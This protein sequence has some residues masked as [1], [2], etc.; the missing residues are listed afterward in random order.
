MSESIVLVISFSAVLNLAILSLLSWLKSKGKPGNFWLGCMFFAASMAILDNSL[1][2]IGKG[3]VSLYHVALMLNLGWGA[4]LVA[5]ARSLR[6]PAEKAI[7][8]NW[9]LFIPVYLYLP[10]FILTLVE[11]HWRTDTITLA[12]AGK[13]TLFGTAYNL[14]ICGYSILSNT[15]LLWQEHKPKPKPGELSPKSKTKEVLWVMLVLQLLAFVPFIL[16]LDISYILLYMP[17]FGQVFFLYIF[18]RITYS[19]HLLFP[20]S[21]REKENN[22][23]AKYSTIK[24]NSER[25][26][27]IRERVVEYMNAKKPYLKMDYSLTDMSRDLKVL[28]TQ[29]S[30]VINSKLNCSFPEY[31]NS[32]RIKRALELLNKASNNN[33]TIEAIAYESGFNNRT[34]FYKAFKKETGK[35]PKDFLKKPGKIKEIV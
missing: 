10:F 21:Q 30:M 18:F 17:V 23:A 25:A 33:L 28:P 5:F 7:R 3:M 12:K 19:S 16:K 35:L 22:P 13:M 15:A 34:S 8:Y 1:I 29:L 9:K 6:N 11:P 32:L 20:A 4:Y 2:Y 26:E 27:E 14:L 24:L 31:L